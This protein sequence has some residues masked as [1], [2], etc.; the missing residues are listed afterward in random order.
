MLSELYIKN[1]ALIEEL[2]IQFDKGL[3]IITGE[4]G[5]GKS[6]MIDALS[7]ALGKKGSKSI[8]R[9]GQNKAI[10]EA[11]FFVENNEI[12]E[13]LDEL[14][15]DHEEDNIVISREI[16]SDGRSV[17]RV[18]GRTIN[19]SNLKQIT[20]QLITIH[21]QNEYEQLMTSA[22]QLRLIDGYGGEVIG[23]SLVA[24][25][26]EYVKYQDLKNQ[27]LELND[28]MD[29]SKIQRELG[30]L[31]HEISEIDAVQLKNNEKQEIQEYLK[32]LEN[33]EKIFGNLQFVYDSIYSNGDSTLD[34]L[35]RCESK[36]DEI[37]AYD[38]NVSKWSTVLKDAYYSLE[39]MIHE[40]KNSINEEDDSGDTIDELNTRLDQINQLFRKYGKTYEEV[41]LYRENAE[42]RKNTIL[43]RDEMTLALKKQMDQVLNLMKEYSSELTKKRKT[44]TERLVREI[45]GELDSLNMKNAQLKVGFKSE[46]YNKMGRDQI[47]FLVSFN[48][49]EELKPFNK[50]ASGGEISRFM[51][52]FKTVVAKS[53]NIDSLIFDEIDTGVSGISAHKI[54]HKLKEISNFR[55]VICITH[56]PQIASF[57]D[58]HFIVEKFQ[59][60][61]ETYTQIEE[62]NMDNRIQEIA[63]M[64]SGSNITSSTIQTAADLITKN[65]EAK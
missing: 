3:N 51:L 45:Q 19:Q 47:E 64:M 37:E 15:I 43:S 13:L 52:A 17:S 9:T 54:G 59:K 57:A 65:S 4:T 30:L 60:N 42:K 21:G 50:I 8:V 24:Y 28:D 31:D 12:F 63:K 62:L 1:F 33:S 61:S 41:M 18:N 40:I 22:N 25:Q 27:I 34:I 32:R 55:Q 46:N 58:T 7:L 2:R 49:G 5:S 29:A 10:V 39:D 53:D 16:S 23:A 38:P 36:L 44:T 56:L 26:G 48:K 35:S 20:S 14:G 6:I 11:V